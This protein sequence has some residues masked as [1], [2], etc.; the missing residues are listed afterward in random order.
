MFLTSR[1]CCSLSFQHSTAVFINEKKIHFILDL[2]A[3]SSFGLYMYMYTY[4]SW[5]VYTHIYIYMNM[6]SYI[7][8]DMYINVY[9]YIGYMYVYLLYIAI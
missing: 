8:L 9:V 7:M 3:D 6:Y 1:D 2:I 5:A 4:I